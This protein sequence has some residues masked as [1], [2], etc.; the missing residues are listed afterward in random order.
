MVGIAAVILTP[1]GKGQDEH[2][3]QTQKGWGTRCTHYKHRR[4]GGH[5]ALTTNTEGVGDTVHSLQTQKGWG[6]R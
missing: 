5:G 3:L 4:G 6:T 2:S 1:G